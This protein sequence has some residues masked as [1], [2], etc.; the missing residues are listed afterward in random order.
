MHGREAKIV[1]LPR[2]SLQLGLMT[3]TGLIPVASEAVDEL[4]F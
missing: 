4:T 1:T 2:A 3:A